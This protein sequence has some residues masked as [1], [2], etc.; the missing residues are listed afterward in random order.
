MAC[1]AA[2][3][4][5]RVRIG[6]DTIPRTE[7]DTSSQQMQCHACVIFPQ[8]AKHSIFNMYSSRF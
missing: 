2:T 6:Y 5:R 8:E 4:H 7:P 3:K 1:M